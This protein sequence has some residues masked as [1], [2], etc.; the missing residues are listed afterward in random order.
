MDRSGQ[1]R[2][3]ETKLSLRERL[4]SMRALLV[5]SLL[6]ME[7]DDEAHILELVG[8]SVSSLAGQLLG[9]WVADRGWTGARGPC[10]DPEVQAHLE[11]QFAVLGD[12]GGEVD[13]LDIRWAA[14]FPLRSVAGSFGYLVVGA[15][16]RPPAS[17]QFLVRVLAQHGGVALGNVRLHARERSVVADLRAANARLEMAF[18]AAERAATIHDRLTRVALRGQGTEGIAQVVHELTGYPVVVEDGRGVVVAWAGGEQPRDDPDDPRQ[19]EQFLRRLEAAEAPLRR[20]DRLMAI[21]HPRSGVLGVLSLVDPGGRAG[22][23]ERVALEHGATVLAVELSRLHSLAET[24]LRLGRDLVEELLSGSA[25][26]QVLE[27]ARRVGHDLRRAHRVMV[28]ERGGGGNPADGLL[29]AVQRAQQEMSVVS[30]VA[31][32]HERVVVLVP[33]GTDWRALCAAI[34]R[35]LTEGSC[36]AGVGTVCTH[37]TDFARSYREARLALQVFAVVGGPERAI[38]FEDLGV[39][40]LF[41]DIADPAAVHGLVRE[42]LGALLDYDEANDYELV[43]TLSCYLEAGGGYDRT[44]AALS[45]HRSTL[46]YRL[47]RIREISAHDLSDPRTRFNLQLATRAWQAGEALRATAD[48]DHAFA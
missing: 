48:E 27:R 5:Q 2:E 3:P 10:T 23:Q 38:A 24:E 1:S 22:P 33:E 4:S 11:A 39:Y 9:L 16:D 21:A 13:L 44:A 25:D 36:R 42:W 19:H 7:S 30:L 47:R 28:V 40:G 45:V 15:E 26:D 31:A 6:M 35:T 32:R 12:A 14:A 34:Q 29:R 37:P 46:K 43:K 18:A 8:S 41:L 17:R 20:G